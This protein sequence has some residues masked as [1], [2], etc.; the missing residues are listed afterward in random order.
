MITQDQVTTVMGATVY[1][2]DGEK[3]GKATQV[4]L[5]DETG[6]PDWVTVSTGLFSGKDSFV[7]LRDARLEGD[8]VHVPYSKDK[9]KDAPRV[10]ADEHLD[11]DE[12]AEL[13]R[14]Y[15]LGGTGVPA[16][17]SP[18]AGMPSGQTGDLTGVGGTTGPD[19]DALSSRDRT[20]GV[21]AGDEVG[22]AAA[23]TTGS[24]GD[25]AM[26]R[27][28][29][30]LQVGG[31]QEREVGRAR[32]RKYVTTHPETVTV[33]VEREEVRLEREP[34][35]AADREA[36]SGPELTDAEHEV[37]LHER[38]PTVE[39][40]V[41]PEERIRLAT[42]QVREDETVTRDVREEHVDIEGGDGYRR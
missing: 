33:P 34:V 5:D 11:I 36:M 2:P 31:M 12:E 40:V 1:G 26:T 6:Q 10:A 28:E 8:S 27:S 18:T 38:R 37:T 39:T 24:V 15:E 32:L 41:T 30:H 22:H 29:E 16:F 3:I 13:Y 14:F 4:Y 19:V 35:S 21:I 9:V 23:A 7:P 25:D 17:G 20:S 42:E